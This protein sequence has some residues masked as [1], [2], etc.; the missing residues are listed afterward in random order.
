MKSYELKPTD[1]NI[2][3]TYLGDTIFRDKEVHFF[4]DILNLVEDSCSIALDGA[5][6]SGK[7]FF[8]KQVKMILDAY[9]NPTL[10]KSKRILSVWKGLHNGEEPEFQVQFCVYYD[11]WENDNDKD[12]VMSLIYSI[13]RDVNIES[14]FKSDTGIFEKAAA[15]LECFTGRNV[16]DFINAL[17]N[18]NALSELQKSKDIHK[19][20]IDFLD[21]LLQERAN[22]LIIIIDELDRCRPDFAVKLLERIKHYFSKD[23]ITFVFATNLNELQHTVSKFYGNE[24]DACRYLDRFFDL[25]ITLPPVNM[26]RYLESIEFQ[27]NDEV[28]HVVCKELIDMF[29]FSLREISRFLKFVQIGIYE[30]TNNPNKYNFNYIDRQAML[31]SLIFLAPLM[32]ALIMKNT[33]E[34]N[35]FVNGA[36][37]SFFIDLMQRMRDTHYYDFKELL[38]DGEEYDTDCENFPSEKSII[39]LELKLTSIYEAIFANRRNDQTSYYMA[40]KL[41]FSKNIKNILLEI[42]SLISKYAK[43]E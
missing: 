24:F 7:T 39:P 2:C 21:D 33:T 10:E 29:D 26:D 23:T 19:T 15:I 28:V 37:D 32:I 14:P 16:I 36:D 18:E 17:K 9:I 42:T 20:I 27:N 13:L 22:R 25:R 38:S 30:P 3:S 43:Y 5:W 4:I 41:K 31:F 34:Y 11:A 35:R 6:G 40:G 1:E 8:V 12:P